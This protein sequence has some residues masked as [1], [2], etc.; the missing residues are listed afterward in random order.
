MAN[1]KRTVGTPSVSGASQPAK[2]A[3]SVE[4]SKNTLGAGPTK[5]ITDGHT[6]DKTSLG[7]AG[8]TS[9]DPDYAKQARQGYYDQHGAWPPCL[10]KYCKSFG[11]PHPN[12]LCYAD[13]PE[14]SGYSSYLAH[15]GEVCITDIEH[16]EKCEHYAD[17]GVVEENNELQN[18]PKFTV[19]HVGAQQGLLGLLTKTGFSK[20]KDKHTTDFIDQA[21][22]G[23]KLLHNHVKDLFNKAQSIVAD[24]DS[25]EALKDHLQDLR[26]NPEKM[27]DIGGN[28]AD[29]MPDHAG[30]LAATAGTAINHLNSLRPAPSQNLPMDTLSDVDKNTDNNY[31]RH[32]D[33]AQNP[34]LI[35][36]H[37]KDG[38]LLPNDVKT[39]QTIYPALYKNMVSK[40]GE[41]LIE[42]KTKGVEIPYKQKMTLS[43]LLGQPLDST[44]TPQAMQ[45]IINSAGPQQAKNQA[46]NQ[47]K[48]SGP[49]ISQINKVNAMDA[50]TSQARQIRKNK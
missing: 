18:N 47:P 45:A 41:Q 13:H 14:G 19:D 23:H 34:S 22:R 27:L 7:D 26:E 21:R 44:Q 30:V 5:T 24:K 36:Q 42:A 16:H 2:A 3:P 15:G 46:R 33:I 29:N 49:E 8:T 6:V 28:L 35:L 43:L 1:N 12:C 10:N 37:T 40:A 20:A 32:L 50:T 9:I 25:R 48:A 31:N 4:Y 11:S 38:T 17:G 39:L